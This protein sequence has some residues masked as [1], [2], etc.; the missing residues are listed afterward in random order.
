M[1]RRTENLRDED[2]Y[3]KRNGRLKNDPRDEIEKR[4]RRKSVT[5]MKLKKIAKK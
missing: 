2:E 4:T 1:E 5:E 3:E